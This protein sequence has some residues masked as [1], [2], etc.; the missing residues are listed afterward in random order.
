MIKIWYLKKPLKYGTTNL[1]YVQRDIAERQSQTNI[2]FGPAD[3]KFR[4]YNNEPTLFDSPQKAEVDDDPFAAAMA[5]G[6]PVNATG[7]PMDSNWFDQ[8]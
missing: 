1:S 3:L 5:S 2:D 4:I 6:I 8:Q 7:M